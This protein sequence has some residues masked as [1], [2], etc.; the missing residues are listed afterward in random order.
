MQQL[1]TG[2]D[3]RS[4]DAPAFSGRSR[5]L[6][7]LKDGPKRRRVGF[8]VQGSPA[9]EGSIIYDAE[10]THQIGEFRRASQASS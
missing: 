7:E 8:T 4:E 5:I 3:R 10:G 6:Q 9:R 1:T 2:K